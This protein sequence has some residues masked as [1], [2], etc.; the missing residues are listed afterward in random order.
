MKKILG[1]FFL[2][3]ISTTFAAQTIQIHSQLPAESPSAALLLVIYD[4]DQGKKTPYFMNLTPGQTLQT[5]HVEGNHFQILQWTI[6]APNLEFSPCSPTPVIDN[7][8]LIVNIIGEIKPNGLRCALREV[9]VIP[10]LSIPTAATASVAPV[11]NVDSDSGKKAI[12]SYLTALSKECQKGKFQANLESQTVT[13][14]ILGM[15]AG[16]C[17]VT[18]GTN[19]LPPLL[20]H[21]NKN[22]IALLASPTEIENYQLGTAAYSENSLSAR[23]MKARCKAASVK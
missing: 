1:F 21:F 13:Y 12:A 4:I 10:Q 2:F 14:S 9:A 19:K 22:D 18:I 3:A 17:D 15:N 16:K 11:A 7:H 8:S 6:Q 23:I 20:C 5:F